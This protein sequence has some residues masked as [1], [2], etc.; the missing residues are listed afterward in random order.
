MNPIKEKQYTIKLDMPLIL[1]LQM[2]IKKMWKA[3]NNFL[4]E[5]DI[6]LITRNINDREENKHMNIESTLLHSI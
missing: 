1:M 6:T 5:K 3:T 4:K 2:I